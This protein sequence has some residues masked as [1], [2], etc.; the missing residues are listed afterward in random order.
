MAANGK[1]RRNSGNSRIGVLVELEDP[2][3]YQ[4]D[5]QQVSVTCLST[6][7]RMSYGKDVHTR[8]WQ[9][10]VIS[11]PVT[12]TFG[13]SSTHT[14]IHALCSR[15]V[16]H[17]TRQ[18]ALKIDETVVKKAERPRGE[19]NGGAQPMVFVHRSSAPRCT[20]RRS[21]YFMHPSKRQIMRK[22]DAFMATGQK[23]APDAAVAESITVIC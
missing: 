6:E 5:N 15:S 22:N 7:F 17:Q 18:R 20:R 21:A 23:S 3:P 16:C 13:P 12:R 19:R 4:T 9:N 1:R 2:R 8:L 10:D 11:V 14:H